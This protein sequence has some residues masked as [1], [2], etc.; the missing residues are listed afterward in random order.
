MPAQHI[1]GKE[2]ERAHE[3]LSKWQVN[4]LNE[5]LDLF[6]IPRGSGDEGKKVRA[7]AMQ[8]RNA[9]IEKVPCTLS[10]TASGTAR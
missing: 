7:Q 10:S 3:R 1:Q 4:L 9:F 5:A 2:K 8:Y 6:D